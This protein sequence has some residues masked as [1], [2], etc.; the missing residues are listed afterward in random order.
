MDFPGPGSMRNFPW[1]LVD[2]AQ[3]ADSRSD[4]L[5]AFVA[6]DLRHQYQIVATSHEVGQTGVAKTA[7]F[8]SLPKQRS[9]LCEFRQSDPSTVAA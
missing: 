2:P 4:G 6:C 7:A 1:P 5:D 3:W 8:A 9:G